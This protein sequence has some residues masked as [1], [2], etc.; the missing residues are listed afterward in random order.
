MRCPG[1][2]CGGTGI[3][4]GRRL[5]WRCAKAAWRA[6]NPARAVFCDV[7]DSARKRGVP[8]ALTFAEFLAA[9]EGTGY[10]QNRGTASDALHMDRINPGEGYVTGNVRV[11]LARENVAKG[12][13]ERHTINAADPPYVKPPGRRCPF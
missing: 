5:C 1:E 10:L 13:V 3:L 7:R 6:A 12:N 2:L 9:V 8:F 11:V 4:K